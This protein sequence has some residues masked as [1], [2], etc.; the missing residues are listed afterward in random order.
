[1]G[2][3]WVSLNCAFFP[4][5][6]SQMALPQGARVVVLRVTSVNAPQQNGQRVRPFRHGDQM[7]MVAHEA[8]T[9]K[10]GLQISAVF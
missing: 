8:P 9:Q 1:M 7:G 5:A 6:F 10:A 3:K 4:A 2:A